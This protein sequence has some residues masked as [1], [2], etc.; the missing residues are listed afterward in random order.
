MSEDEV[1]GT[2]AEAVAGNVTEE[3]LEFN[4]SPPE[5]YLHELTLAANLKELSVS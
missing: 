2:F 4:W 5:Y 3:R 1:Y